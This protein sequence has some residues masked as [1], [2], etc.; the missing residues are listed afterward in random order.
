MWEKTH[1]PDEL[2]SMPE[3]YFISSIEEFQYDTPELLKKG[4]KITKIYPGDTFAKGYNFGFTK[5]PE[6]NIPL[7]KV[8]GWNQTKKS[9]IYLMSLASF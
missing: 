6:K 5:D 8:I 3:S 7:V 2:D 4:Q 1:L 9:M